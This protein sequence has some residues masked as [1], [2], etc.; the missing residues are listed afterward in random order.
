MFHR[1]TLLRK[2]FV[3]LAAAVTSVAALHLAAPAAAQE[4]V[5]RKSILQL[6]FGCG[7]STKTAVSYTHLTLPT[8]YSV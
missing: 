8:I 2:T 6:L 1:L 5:E 3:V 4:R 7:N